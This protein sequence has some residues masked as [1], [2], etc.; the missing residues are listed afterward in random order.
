MALIPFPNVNLLGKSLKQDYKLC[1]QQKHVLVPR[2]F[3]I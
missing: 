3:L 1:S 2:V